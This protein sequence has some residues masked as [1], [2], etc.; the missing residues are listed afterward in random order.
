MYISPLGFLLI[1]ISEP[2]CPII[3]LVLPYPD[4]GILAT[5]TDDLLPD[6]DLQ[7]LGFNSFPGIVYKRVI[8]TNVHKR[9][10]SE[11]TL[12]QYHLNSSLQ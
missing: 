1:S 9:V 8:P 11:D 4:M 6:T 10:L 7:L 2:K 3:E 12:T 5:G